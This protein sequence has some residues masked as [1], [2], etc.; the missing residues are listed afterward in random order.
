MLT[1]ILDSLFWIDFFEPQ[2]VRMKPVSQAL[3]PSHYSLVKDHL[4][5]ELGEK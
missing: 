2:A 5:Q 1:L 4:T 3:N